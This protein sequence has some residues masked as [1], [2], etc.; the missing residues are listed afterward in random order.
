MPAV[1]VNPGAGA[2]AGATKEQACLNIIA[3]CEDLSIPGVQCKEVPECDGEG[4]YT[5]ELT[6]G[7]VGSVVIDMPGLPL[8]QVRWIRSAVHG[9]PDPQDPWQFP[10]LYVD[11]S[12]WL[13][14]F[15]LQQAGLAL[16]GVEEDVV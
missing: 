6:H 2:V 4:R 3:F 7:E 11:G 15:A 10:Q 5:F 1:I 9:D 14:K 8:D 16:L 13:W 12:S